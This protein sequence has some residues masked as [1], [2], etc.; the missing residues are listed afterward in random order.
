MTTG[1]L[2]GG[3]PITSLLL[4]GGGRITTGWLLAKGGRVTTDSKVTNPNPLGRLISASSTTPNFSKCCTN[5]SSV[6]SGD[7]GEIKSDN[8]L[9]SEDD[10]GVTQ[11]MFNN[12]A[13]CEHDKAKTS[14]QTSDS[15]SNYVATSELSILTKTHGLAIGLLS[16][17]E[18]HMCHHLRF[19]Q[20]WLYIWK[21]R[22][23]KV[24]KVRDLSCLNLTG[25]PVARNILTS[26][27]TSLIS[28]EK[29]AGELDEALAEIGVDFRE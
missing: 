15:V 18:L 8:N 10:M 22:N 26:P 16:K 20:W 9:F 25:S 24:A 2:A 7:C 28:S 17:Q 29:T 21:W 27:R 4:E 14:A 11:D 23:D 6:E 1:L 19:T 5:S 12:R 13:V 3:G